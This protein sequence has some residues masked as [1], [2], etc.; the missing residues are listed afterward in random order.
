[1]KNS[2][3]KSG[4]HGESGEL[5]RLRQQVAS[6]ADSLK[7][8]QEQL[9][10]QSKVLANLVARPDGT[11]PAKV[12]ALAVAEA[13]SDSAVTP[14]LLIVMAAAVSSFLGKKVRIRSAKMLQ[15]P[16]EIINPWAQQGRVTVQ[17]SHHPRSA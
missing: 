10:D 9:A 15:S 7:Q 6:L 4:K 14:E 2:K 12:P 13:A 17:A 11:A 16:Y 1:M 3:G 5:A 8:L